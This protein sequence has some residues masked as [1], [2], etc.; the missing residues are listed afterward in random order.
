MIG[1]WLR[2]RRRRKLL[3]RPFPGAWRAY[4]ESLPFY[5]RLNK[6]ERGRLERIAQVLIGE[7]NWEGCDGL[8]ITDEIRVVIAAQAALLLL[9]IEH[10]YFEDVASILVFPTSFETP[11]ETHMGDG[12][13]GEGY[14]HGGEAWYRGPVILAWDAAR[15]GPL[16][17]RDGHN[18]VLHEFAHHLDA[19]NGLF[20]G[21]P[22]LG[23]QAAY[24]EWRDVMTAAYEQLQ[25][26]VDAGR[27]TVLD[28]YGATDEAEFFAVATETFFEKPRRLQRKHPELYGVLRA[29]Y[30][31][32][33][34]Q[35]LAAS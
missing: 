3:E 5:E 23:R 9:E 22:S 2:R 7:K 21:T 4:L 1:A 35:R 25:D 15:H 31:Q 17:P 8:V 6:D 24:D 27:R 28:A 16:D 20:D 18:L 30:R 11:F 13:V 26:D 19:S 34:L 33:P 12:I 14:E 29:Y 32:D 10:D